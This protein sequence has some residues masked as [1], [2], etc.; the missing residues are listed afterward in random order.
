MCCL[1]QIYRMTSEDLKYIAEV[2]WS[3]ILFMVPFLVF[4]SLTDQMLIQFFFF[5]FF[6]LNVWVY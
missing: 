6:Q 5:Y 4:L 1:K 2:E 3:M